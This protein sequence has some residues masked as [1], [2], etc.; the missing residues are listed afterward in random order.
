MKWLAIEFILLLFSLN[1]LVSQDLFNRAEN[2]YGPDPLLYNGKKYTFFLPAGTEGNQYF[3]DEQFTPGTVM[4]KGITFKTEE[5]NYDIL[6]QE[7]LLQYSN[8]TG[9]LNLIALSQSWVG[10]FQLHD[11]YF[12]FLTIPEKPKRIY[13]VIRTGELG[14]LFYWYKKLKLDMTY[15]SDKY[16]FSLPSRDSYIQIEDECFE[17]RNNKTFAAA[18]EADSRD[19]IRKYIKSNHIRIQ[20]ASDRSLAELLKFCETLIK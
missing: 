1:N 12:E 10:S 16:E 15:G 7:I 14:V 3:S 6:N 9:A 5:L 20:K 13:Q 18:F 8:E 2:T 19:E 11:R 4:I 17:F